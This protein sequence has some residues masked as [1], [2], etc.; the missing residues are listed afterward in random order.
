MKVHITNIYGHSSV[1]TALKAQNRTADIAR[2]VLN[3]NELGIYSYNVNADSTE[4]LSK[5]LD[6]IIASVGHGDI[7]VFQ[8]PTWNDIKFDK[9]LISSLS[10]YRGL[11]KYFLSMIF[12]L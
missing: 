4:M 3:F 1:S 8:Y 10:H 6:G 11:K 5:R 12:F 2:K 7:V 9:G